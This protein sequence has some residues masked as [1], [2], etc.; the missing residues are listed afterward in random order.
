[1]LETKHCLRLLEKTLICQDIKKNNMKSTILEKVRS[2]DTLYG[3]E[4]EKMSHK[5]IQHILSWINREP[6]YIIYSF[7]DK[8]KGRGTAEIFFLSLKKSKSL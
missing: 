6:L 2:A 7:I 3:R 4:R 5:K 1:M 8:L